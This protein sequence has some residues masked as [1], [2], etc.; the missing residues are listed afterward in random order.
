MGRTV[1]FAGFCGKRGKGRGKNRDNAEAQSR[2]RKPAS[3]GGRYKRRR[4]NTFYAEDNTRNF[5]E[6]RVELSRG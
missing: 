1:P 6:K 4:E 5:V 2:D 3:E